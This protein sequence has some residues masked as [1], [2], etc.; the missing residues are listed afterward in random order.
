MMTLPAVTSAFD[1]LP[2]LTSLRHLDLSGNAVSGHEMHLHESPCPLTSLRHLTCLLL[3]DNDLDPED[4]AT[5]LTA[6]GGQ[7][8]VLGE[9]GSGL[10]S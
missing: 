4:M 10:T 7:L 8:R 6:L 2:S 9:W 3:R 5:L 1:I